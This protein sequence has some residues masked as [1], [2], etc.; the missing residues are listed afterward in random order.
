MLAVGVRLLGD[1]IADEFQDLVAGHDHGAAGQKCVSLSDAAPED[2]AVPDRR[3]L[4]R[5]E[6][7]APCVV[8]T[9]AGDQKRAVVGAGAAAGRLVDE[10]RADAAGCLLPAGQMM[11]AEDVLR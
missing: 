11:A 3:T 1:R 6:L 9:V 10:L 5:V 7:F 4:L 8:N 2:A